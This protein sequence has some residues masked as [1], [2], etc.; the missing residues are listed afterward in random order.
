MSYVIDTHTHWTP[1]TLIDVLERRVEYPRIARENGTP[2]FEFGPGRPFKLP[3]DMWNPDAKIAKMDAAGIDLSVIS[4]VGGVAVVD[5][6]DN[7]SD[8]IAVARAANDE[9][10]DLCRSHPTRFAGLAALPLLAGTDNAIA[11]LERAATVGLKGAMVYSNVHGRHLDDPEFLPVFDAAAKLG[12]VIQ[13]HP[14]HPLAAAWLPN[15]AL[16]TAVG[17]L[18]DTTTAALR[19]IFSGV[20]DR[21]PGF[22]LMLCHAGSLLPFVTARID[23][24]AVLFPNDVKQLSA[25]PSEYIKKLYTDIVCRHPG[26]ARLAL[27]THGPERTMFGTDDP[28]WPIDG[29]FETLE[30]LSLPPAVREQVESGTARNVFGLGVA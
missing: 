30:A 27:D 6:V 10:A 5:L 12:M 8:A 7:P 20:Y 21:N 17:Y 19:L 2:H 23:Y 9:L 13:I 4:V 22:K 29:A 15:D 3:D 25:P 16:I 28:Y 18:F 26:V 11:E 24:Q 1:S 14:T